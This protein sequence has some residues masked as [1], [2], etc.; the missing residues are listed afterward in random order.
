MTNQQRV[1]NREQL[2]KCF[3]DLAA[4]SKELD[5][6]CICSMCYVIAGTIMEGSDEFL[7]TWMA[8][9]AKM[10]IDGIGEYLEDDET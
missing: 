10:R 8:E 4:R 6:E 1:A 2:K 9:Y 3:L 5:E 7:A